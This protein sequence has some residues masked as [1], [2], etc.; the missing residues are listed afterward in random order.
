MR[1]RSLVELG[2]PAA[3]ALAFG[4]D[5][6]QWRL[7]G[8]PIAGATG[9]SYTPTAADVGHQLSCTVTGTYPL[10]VVTVSSTSAAR[11]VLT[12]APVLSL[13]GPIT[14][15]ATGPNGAVVT[16]TATATDL[17]DG[18]VPV[19]CTPPSGSVFPIG[20]TTVHCNAVD[21]VGNTASGSFTVTVT[22]SDL[23]H[24]TIDFRGELGS[25]S[26]HWDGDVGSGRLQ[27]VTDGNVEWL[28]GD[29]VFGSPAV[30]LSVDLR[31]RHVARLMSGSLTATR[32]VASIRFGLTI[33]PFVLG[34]DGSISNPIP[35]RGSYYDGVNVTFGFV[36]VR[37]S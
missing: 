33:A 28:A 2:R 12:T 1:R 17:I 16:Y 5:G 11:T 25:P 3:F 37:F 34:A 22:A 6:Y 9:P 18:T 26:L 23:D 32:G 21:S 29:A 20:T 19:S 10:L 36:T 4:F 24:V 7:D 15:A 31:S 8:N 14:V 35:I 30:A 13:P 27:T